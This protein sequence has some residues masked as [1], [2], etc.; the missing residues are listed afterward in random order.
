MVVQ[1]NLSYL[2]VYDTGAYYVGHYT[3]DS[4]IKLIKVSKSFT[5]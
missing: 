5:S 1:Q 3:N 4:F 2:G